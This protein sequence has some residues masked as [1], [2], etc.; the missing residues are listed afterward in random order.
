MFPVCPKSINSKNMKPKK[1]NLTEIHRLYLVL[2]HALPDKEEA[3]LIDEI[4]KIL[5]RAEPNTMMRCLEIMYSKKPNKSDPF[6]LLLLFIKGLQI[7][8]F[9]EYSNFINGLKRGR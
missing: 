5:Q 1:L 6:N 3:L 2:R 9:F 7:N 8:D 4:E